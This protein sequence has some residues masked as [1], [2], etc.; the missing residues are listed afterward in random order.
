[1]QFHDVCA[2]ATIYV[3]G[4]LKALWKHSSPGKGPELVGKHGLLPML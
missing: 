4:T 2:E 1:M 3:C